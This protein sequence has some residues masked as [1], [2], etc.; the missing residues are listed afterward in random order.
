MLPL[1]CLKELSVQRKIQTAQTILTALPYIKKF[2]KKTIVIKYGGAAQINPDLKERFAQDLVLLYLV[3]IKP[4]IVHGGGKRINELLDKLQL[5][6][7][8]IDGM[9]ITD[10]KVMEVVEMVLSGSI[11][12]EITTLLNHHGAKAIGISGKDANFI[13]AKPLADG[14]Y[15][16]VGEITGVD[17][18]V[19]ENLIAE[20]FIP[21]IAPIGSGGD[22]V[23]PGY[24]INADLAAS[25]IAVSLQAEKVLFLTDT[26]GVLDKSGNL[27]SSLNAQEVEALKCDGTIYGG[28]L[29]KVS[30][31][32][33]ALQGGVKHA[34]IIDGRVEHS[35]VL[36]L[37]T[38]E[39]IGTVFHA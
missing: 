14:K 3:G 37:F 25:K 13:K 9:R 30:A 19:L 17:H 10:E 12:K 24:N 33:E 20:K 26:P 8:F 18:E 39:G 34:H 35:L 31:C 22:T 21:V 23:H 5:G 16:L 32:M 36:E 15:G 7:E 1:F 29:P 38:D 28:M 11:N 2:T 27:L 6:T 4:V